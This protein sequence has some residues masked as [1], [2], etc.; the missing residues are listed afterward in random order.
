[1]A[2]GIFKSS[3]TYLTC[4]SI[5]LRK[6]IIRVVVPAKAN[7]NAPQEVASPVLGTVSSLFL[8]DWRCSGCCSYRC[9]G[10]VGHSGT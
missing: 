7:S 4:G 3:S 6:P 1:M 10:S 2:E 5:F 8:S 9:R